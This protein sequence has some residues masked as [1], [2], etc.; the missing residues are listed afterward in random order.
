LHQDE[1]PKILDQSKAP[2]WH[3]AMLSE[4]F[5]NYLMNCEESDSDFKQLENNQKIK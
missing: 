5:D 2:E 4:N 1:I 3:A